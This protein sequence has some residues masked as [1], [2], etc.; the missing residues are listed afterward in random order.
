M[1]E[2]QRAVRAGGQPARRRAAARDHHRHE[3]AQDAYAE[4]LK[5]A[6][7]VL[8]L[9][10][11]LHSIAVGNML[12]SWVKIVCVDINPA[13]ATKVSDRGT[14]Q[15][16]GVVT[17]VGLFLD[18]LSRT[19]IPR[20]DL[21]KMKRQYTDEHACRRAR[22]A[23]GDRDLAEPISRLR[24]R[25]RPAGVHFGL[26]Q[27]GLPDHGE[28]TLRYVPD[29]LCLELKSLKM[30]MLAYRNLGIFQ[31]NVVNRFSARRGEGV[32]ADGGD[33]Y[34]RVY[35]A[36][37]CLH[38]NYGELEQEN[39]DDPKGEELAAV[40]AEIRQRVRARNPNGVAP[41][42]I[43]LPDLT[44]LLH[45]RDAAEAKV[46]SIGTVN[47][48]RGGLKN[49]IIQRLKRMVARALDWHVRE[50]VEFNRGVMAC[51]QAT[52]EALN[53]CKQALSLLA[54]FAR[55]RRLAN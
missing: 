35:A 13:V 37:R 31:E 28:L 12:P 24:D 44:P 9:G 1:R 16:V 40:I 23:A 41:G 7:L 6:G 20:N 19:L 30:Y 48:R 3:S 4:R 17:D 15:A 38:E 14:G 25:N 53:E 8:C 18:L 50:Q 27:D 54:R 2:E 49:S 43:P 32:P 33:A 42:N 55:L 46:A 10:S 39:M 11:M 26:S 36:R 51:V 22:A 47:P 29:K 52:M 34:G 5:G 45:A 21:G